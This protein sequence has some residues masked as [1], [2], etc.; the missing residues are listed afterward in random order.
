M[1]P[2]STRM[3]IWNSKRK[4]GVH[5][6]TLQEKEKEMKDKWKYL[7]VLVLAL[8]ALLAGRVT[9]WGEKKKEKEGYRIAEEFDSTS[10]PQEESVDRDMIH[11]LKNRPEDHYRLWEEDTEEMQIT[12]Q[13]YEEHPEAFAWLSRPDW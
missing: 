6:D 3:I 1:E 11:S 5:L 8:L 4:E 7:L 9:D 13:G 10:P 12:F 2:Q